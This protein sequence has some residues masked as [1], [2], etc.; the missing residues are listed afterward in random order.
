MSVDRGIALLD[1]RARRLQIVAVALGVLQAMLVAAIAWLLSDT[2]SRVFL[3]HARLSSVA[4]SLS[5]LLVLAVLR[6]GLIGSSEVLSQRSASRVKGILRARLSQRLFD[7]G[8]VWAREERSGELVNTLVTGVETLDE[9]VTQYQPARLLAGIVPVLLFLIVLALDPWTALVLVFAGPMLV[10]LLVLIGARARVLSE[11]RFLELNWMSAH[12]LDMV[13]GLATLKMFGRSKEHASIIDEMGQQFSNA[14]MD[15]L[16]TAFQTSLML[17]WAT[18]AT[19]AF[20]ALELSLH[21]LIPFNTALLLLLLTPEVFLPV[22]QLASKYHAGTA[23]KAAAE[24]ILTFLDAP[25]AVTAPS[26]PTPHTGAPAPASVVVLADA[27]ALGPR[28]EPY[29]VIRP[30]NT[31]GTIEFADVSFTYR[32]SQQAALEGLNVRIQQGQTVALVGPTGAGKT[33]VASLLLRF[34]E[35]TAGTIS[36]AGTPLRNL[37]PASWR[38]QV[39]WVPQQPHLFSGTVAENIRLGRPDATAPEIEAAARAAHADEFILALPRGYETP[40]HER[41]LRLSGGQRQRIAIAR[42]FLK[43]T[44]LLILDEATAHLDTES[45]ALIQDALRR[46]TRGRTTLIIAHR[47]RMAYG[48]D[49]IVVMDHGCALDTGDHRTLLAQSS[50]YQTLVAKYEEAV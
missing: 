20:V 6:A 33:T 37:D 43:D 7:R 12:F 38:A 45:E 2:I 24:R 18:T 22:R 31:V 29:S 4:P 1:G 36:V 47:L 30:G 8:P 50:L 48:A 49:T 11:R 25:P 5:I 17:E 14:T 35:P 39:G 9:Y 16:R 32:N 40:I 41:G 27:A 42:A 13:Q 21:G 3:A 46:L 34:I 15:V 23:G 28:P 44:P 19:T 26:S 10:L